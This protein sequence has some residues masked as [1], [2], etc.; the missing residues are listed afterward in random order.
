MWG[1]FSENSLWI[2]IVSAVLVIFLLFTG[3]KIRKSFVSRAKENNR[4]KTNKR[5][6]ITL[7]VFEIVFAVIMICT[8]VPMLFDGNGDEPVITAEKA[9]LWLAEHGLAVV[10]T[11]I[12]GVALWAAFKRFFPVIIK[13][14]MSRPMAGESAEGTKRRADTLIRVFLGVGRVIIVVIVILM[15]LSELGLPVGPVLAGFG[16]VGIAVGFGAQYLI[17]DLIAGTF[18]FMENQYRIGDVIRIVDVSGTVEEINLR[19]TVIRDIDGA[20]HHV[21]NGEIRIASN[22]SRH[23]ARINLD[24]SVSYKT[25]LELAIS[26]INCVCADMAKEDKWKSALRTVPSVLRVNKLNDSGV[27]LK[28]TGEVRPLKQWEVMGELRLRIKNAFDKEGI[29]IPYPHRK[30]V[31]DNPPGED[32]KDKLK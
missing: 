8:F 12:V 19:K 29:E 32:N 24:I 21:P 10:I 26:V 18:I 3:E 28:I 30:V 14:I 15:V 31:F 11:I 2:L 17:R 27:E 16:V 13:N 25:N 20:V 22:L 23:Y 9:N 7:W 6:G 1:W 4:E 5:T